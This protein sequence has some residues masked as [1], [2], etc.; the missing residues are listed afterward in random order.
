MYRECRYS[1]SVFSGIGRITTVFRDSG[2][3][4]L[5]K[6]NTVVGSPKFRRDCERCAMLSDPL[7]KEERKGSFI[8]VRATVTTISSTIPR[9]Q[10]ARSPRMK[11]SNQR[12]RQPGMNSIHPVPLFKYSCSCS[13]SGLIV[14][15]PSKPIHPASPSKSCSCKAL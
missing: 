10:R 15:D 11:P 3:T 1:T 5:R 6:R 13:H 2:E 12:V 14:I 7:F 8:Y 4:R 9:R